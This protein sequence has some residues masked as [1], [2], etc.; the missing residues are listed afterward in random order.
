MEGVGELT[1][2]L[3][4]D[5]RVWSFTPAGEWE[6]A[7]EPLHRHWESFTT[8]HQELNRPGLP[9]DR[10]DLSNA[11]LARLA[12]RE[13]LY[14]CG[15]GLAFGIDRATAT[16]KPVGLLPCAHGGTTLE[17][18]SFRHKGR[19]GASLY[20]A[21]LERVRRAGGNLC[22][23]LWYQGESEGWSQESC[24]AYGERFAEWVG[25]LRKDFGRPEFPVLTVQIGR[26]MLDTIDPLSW[27]KIRHVQAA[28]PNS[29][30]FTAATSAVDLPLIDAIH[31]NA[32]GLRRLGRRLARIAGNMEKGFVAGPK[33]IDVC[34]GSE[35]PD[36][37]LIRLQFSGVTGGWLPVDNIAGF[38]I[39][40][41]EH[42]PHPVNHV[43]N[44]FRDKSDPAN[45][46]VRTNL[47]V[48]P[49]D[50][51]AYGN[52]LRPYCNAIDEADMPLSAFEV[53]L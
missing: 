31:I 38:D 35:P 16:G 30:P 1:D 28:F 32:S 37:G 33:L 21:M 17:Q 20:G 8:V 13:R 19:G 7:A 34:S 29:V 18:W 3:A 27:T 52:G 2:T 50:I 51:L 10:R 11:E 25:E 53:T 5:P 47:P 46:L 15:L 42:V 44:A 39:L 41:P 9:D 45:I 24:V 14:G 4:P 43:I 48:E 12:S 40:T 6:V 49:G 36:R 23:M 22:G 26:T